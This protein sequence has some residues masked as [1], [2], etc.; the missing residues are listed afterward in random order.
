MC[1]E[2]ICKIGYKN[3]YSKK[4]LHTIINVNRVKYK[5]NVIFVKF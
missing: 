2:Q 4:E 5:V 1:F 3:L